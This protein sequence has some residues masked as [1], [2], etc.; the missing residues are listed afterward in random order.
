MVSAVNVNEIYYV[1]VSTHWLLSSNQYLELLK[2][3]EVSL[4]HTFVFLC[5]SDNMT[6]IR[7]I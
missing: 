1:T 4:S 3:I 2:E 6:D 7:H 5:T